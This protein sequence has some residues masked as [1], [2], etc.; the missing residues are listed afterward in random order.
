MSSSV[1]FTTQSEAGASKCFKWRKWPLSGPCGTETVEV[2]KQGNKQN[3]LV[4]DFK[5]MFAR[6]ISKVQLHQRRLQSK[7]CKN[8]KV[9]AYNIKSMATL[10]FECKFVPSIGFIV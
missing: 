4:S 9:G 3:V 10:T 8:L 7:V 5:K 2:K 1:P 6:Q